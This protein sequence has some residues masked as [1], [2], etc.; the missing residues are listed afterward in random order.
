MAKKGSNTKKTTKTKSQQAKDVGI[1]AGAVATVGAVASKSAGK[2]KSAKQ[3]KQIRSLAFVL[4]LAIIVCGVLF[5]M[6]IAPF[7]FE[8]NG[9][10]FKYYS[11]TPIVPSNTLGNKTVSDFRLHVIDV[12]QGDCMLLELPD[13]KTMLIDGAKKS[14]TIATGIVDY[15]LSDQIGLKDSS[16]KVTL[17]YVMLTHTD[18]DHCGSLDDVIKSNKIDVLNVYRPLIM[19]KY[20]DDPLKSYAVQNN[21]SYSTITTTVYSEFVQAVAEEDGCQTFYNYGDNKLE[22]AGY[23]MYFYNPTP[24]M[25]VDIKT[26]ADKNNVSPVIIIDVCGRKIALTGDADKEQELNFISQVSDTKY[27]LDE[28]FVD[29]DILK[30]AHHGGKESST[31]E[32]LKVVKPE[33]ALISVGDGNSYGH[34]TTEVLSRLQNVG[35]ANVYRTDKHGSIVVTVSS[36]EGVIN[37]DTTKKSN[38]NA[39]R[40][41]DYLRANFDRLTLLARVKY[42]LF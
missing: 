4:V 35:C 26:A 1:F 23:V 14:N 3:K 2:G 10:F 21:L 6:D 7:N 11:Y 28:S 41:N 38:T 29:V 9:D 32:F 34:P 42:I 39:T 18:A 13:G 27:G 24:E 37:V 36:A 8:I 25:Y 33:Y 31:E 16:G 5:Y 19:S 30:V 20:A 12:N 17:D 15:L 40:F 22:G